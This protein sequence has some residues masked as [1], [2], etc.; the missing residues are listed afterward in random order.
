MTVTTLTADPVG[1][2]ATDPT[3]DPELDLD[4]VLDTLSEPPHDRGKAAT[5]WSNLTPPAA[6][7][8]GITGPVPSVAGPDRQGALNALRTALHAALEALDVLE[9][10]T[11]PRLTDHDDSVGD[12]I[13]S[14]ESPTPVDGDGITSKGIPYIADPRP[15]HNSA[16]QLEGI[17]PWSL[18]SDAQKRVCR[19]IQVRDTHWIWS[20]SQQEGRA[21]VRFNGTLTTVVRVMAAICF[22]RTIMAAERFYRVCPERWCVR[23]D[24]PHHAPQR[25]HVRGGIDPHWYE[26]DAYGRT[27]AERAARGEPP[28]PT[29][30]YVLQA[31]PIVALQMLAATDGSYTPDS[32]NLLEIDAIDDFTQPPQEK[33]SPVDALRAMLDQHRERGG[34]GDSVT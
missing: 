26:L 28:L 7:R 33:A 13:T 32:D 34:S 17:P 10:A 5:T 23:P 16:P 12:G 24:A 22:R 21:V 29:T 8:Q 4:A 9:Y 11:A 18:L 30:P 3:S 2:V 19:M 25:P 1:S 14:T 15:R 31:D 27:G 20:S 6:P